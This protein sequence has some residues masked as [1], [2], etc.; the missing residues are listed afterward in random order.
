MGTGP[1]FAAVSAVA[2][3]LLAIIFRRTLGIDTMSHSVDHKS[4]SRLTNTARL[5]KQDQYVGRLSFL[6]VSCV[7]LATDDNI[8]SVSNSILNAPGINSTCGQQRFF[9]LVPATLVWKSDIPDCQSKFQQGD[10]FAWGVHSLLSARLPWATCAHNLLAIPDWFLPGSGLHLS[11]A[12][13]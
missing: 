13:L 2:V 5:E 11:F 12:F 6:V 10:Q 1:Y 4:D 9:R 7:R 3:T 8:I